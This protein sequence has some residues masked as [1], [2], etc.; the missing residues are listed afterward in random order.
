MLA[1]TLA[2]RPGR[3]L[4][5]QVELLADPREHL[6]DPGHVDRAVEEHRELVATQAG[7]GVGG[8]D[9]L[10]Q[11]LREHL[12][13]QVAGLVAVG[14]VHRL[15]AVEVEVEHRRPLAVAAGQVEPVLGA[16]EEQRPVGQL[17]ERVV[18]RRVPEFLLQLDDPPEVGLETAAVQ[19]RGHVP[20]EG[21]QQLEVA[22]S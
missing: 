1:P 22:R 5:R 11:P 10:V 7:G 3:Q 2:V 18:H 21:L 12:E 13:Q 8:A 17:G 20:G 19:R 4:D 6:L 16:V 9:R 15:E 14:V